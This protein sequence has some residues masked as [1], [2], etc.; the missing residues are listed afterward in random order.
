MAQPVKFE[1]SNKELRAAPG[2]EDV[3]SS[4]PIVSIP[5]L[6]TGSVWQL[7]PEELE[8]INK[9]GKVFLS[10]SAGGVTQPPVYITAY[11]PGI[12]QYVAGEFI[13]QIEEAQE[14]GK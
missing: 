12:P 8:T 13:R 4:L 9:T 7:A 5:G 10:V 14:K 3:V 2:D 11:A 6:L 1:E